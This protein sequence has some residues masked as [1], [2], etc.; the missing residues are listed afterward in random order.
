MHVIYIQDCHGLQ[1]DI[2]ALSG[3][4]AHVI[5]NNGKC[6]DYVDSMAANKL[7]CAH[8]CMRMGIQ[9]VIV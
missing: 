4:H 6:M 3:Y 5:I 9:H 2:V 8:M 7:D 1:S